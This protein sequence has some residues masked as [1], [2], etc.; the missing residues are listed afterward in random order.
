MRSLAKLDIRILYVILV[1]VILVP[2]ANPIGLP[3]AIG[4]P[5]R[6]GY[7]FINA[8]PADSIGVFVIDVAPSS[9]AENWPQALAVAKHAMK[10]G[11]KIMAITFVAEGP[12]YEDRLAQEIAPDYGYVYGTD[13]VIMPYRAGAES[14]VQ[15]FGEDLR[16][17]YDADYY[18]TPITELPLMERIQSIADVDYWASFSSGDT[19]WYFVRQ[20]E[21]KFGTPGLAGTVGPGVSG[22]MV[23]FASGQL[24]GMLGGMAGAAEYEFLAK[25][26]GK[27]LAA[28]DAQSIGHSYFIIL[29][30]VSNI[31]Y[32][33][34][35][36]STAGKGAAR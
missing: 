4:E 33:A 10:L 25:T 7:D 34:V 23:Y 8:M 35:R 3:L 22:H 36:S 20:V 17:M 14:A 1:A 21:A 26:P 11:H 13:I 19:G 12:M 32:F 18:D 27:A 30:I 9:E 15:A 5:A 31:V 6:A 28:M 29:M 2:L 16:G 24:K